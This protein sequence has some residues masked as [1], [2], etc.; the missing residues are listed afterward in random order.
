MAKFN[1]G[2][3]PTLLLAVYNQKQETLQEFAQDAK[4]PISKQLM[5]T[6]GTKHALQCRGFMQALHEW[7]W[8]LAIQHTWL[9][10]KNHCT[11]AFNKYQDISHLTGS[12]LMTQA[13]AVVDDAQ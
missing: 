9:N 7:R 4:V 10:W 5:V 8:L 6:T 2:I 3:N 13:N 12:T 11:A 1:K